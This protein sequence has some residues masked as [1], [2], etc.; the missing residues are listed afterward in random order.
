MSHTVEDALRSVLH[1]LEVNAQAQ[2]I[3]EQ[4]RK[5]RAE[6]DW[7]TLKVLK[8]D[9]ALLLKYKEELKLRLKEQQSKENQGSD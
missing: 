5:A 8:R 7:E 9:E 2:E 3:F 1:Q 4:E 6:F